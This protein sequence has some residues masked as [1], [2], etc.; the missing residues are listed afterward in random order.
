MAYIRW[1]QSNWL[2]TNSFYFFTFTS[3][4]DIFKSST[5]Y[6]SSIPVFQHLS[7]FPAP[8]FAAII[9][10]IYVVVC[11]TVLLEVFHQDKYGV[12]Y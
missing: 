10:H 4:F 12:F 8:F 11:I 2:H 7:S 3:S 1:I 6:C 9:L 5:L